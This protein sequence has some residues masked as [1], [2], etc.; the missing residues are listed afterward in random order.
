MRMAGH[1]G[2]EGHGVFHADGQQQQPTTT[3][4]AQGFDS[5]TRQLRLSVA[6]AAFPA[7]NGLV[8]GGRLSRGHKALGRRTD[9]FVPENSVRQSDSHYRQIR[10]LRDIRTEGEADRERE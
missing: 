8:V 4:F 1:G 7:I 2:E 6:T 3:C 9:T 5:R 10:E